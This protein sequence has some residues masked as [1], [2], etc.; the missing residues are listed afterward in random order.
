M[1]DTRIEKL[2]QVLVHYSLG[3][4]PGDWLLLRTSPV[5]DELNLAVYEEAVKAGAF[6]TPCPALRERRN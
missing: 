6:V 5:A 1:S 4:K 3:I 2:A